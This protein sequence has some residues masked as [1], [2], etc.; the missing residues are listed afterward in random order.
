MIS[1]KEMLTQSQVK[2]YD[3]NGYV[4]VPKVFDFT[5]CFIMRKKAE[6]VASKDHSVY[7]NIHRQVPF[8]A[9]I[10]RDRLLVQMVKQVQR[11][12]VVI[13]NDQYL[14]KRPGTSYAKQAWNPHQD[15]TYVNAPYG[16]YMQAFIFL[17][18]SFKER[19]GLYFYPK[20]H[21]E[22]MLPYEYVKS[23]RERI[24]QDGIS[25]PGW[26]VNV[27]NGYKRVDIIANTGDVCLQHGNLIHGSYPNLSKE[28]SREQYSIAYLN[29]GTKIHKGKASIKMAMAT[30]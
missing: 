20:S 25:R 10:A 4:I 23:W 5:E 27:P 17:E 9:A 18:L 30:E 29:E 13:T 6:R 26:K 1:E 11:S 15:A 3:R 16:T 12:K 2:F 21:K 24:D 14:Y 19:G 7:L 22:K 28:H 8:F